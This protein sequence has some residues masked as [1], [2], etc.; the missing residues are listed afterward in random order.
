LSLFRS[1]IVAPIVLAALAVALA[2]SAEAANTTANLV[3]G[4]VDFAHNGANLADGRGLY[5]P[6]AVALDHSVTPNR[7]YVADYG[8][9]RVLGWSSSAN[10][11]N[12]KAANLVIGQPD[13]SSVVCDNGGVSSQTL[14]K[15]SGVAVD[16]GGN[17]YVADSGNNRVLEYNSPYSHAAVAGVGDNIANRVFGQS[18]FTS[19]A[20]TSPVSAST[21]CAPA[22]VAVDSGNNLY[23]ADS[24]NNRVLEYNTPLAGGN[25]VADLVFGQKSMT[26]A[27]CNF[28]SNSVGAS[29]LCLP[30]G[31]AADGAGNLYVGD[32][33]NNRVLKY[34]APVASRNTVADLVFGQSGF[35]ANA[36]SG[37]ASNTLCG[38]QGVAVDAAGNL[39]VADTGNRRALEYDT[40]L[41]ITSTPGSGDTIADRVFGQGN[42]FASTL[43]NLFG[44]A[45]AANSLCAPQGLATDNSENLYIADTGNS[46]LLEYITPLTTTGV[47]GSGDTVA[48]AVLGKLNFVH[49]GPNIARAQGLNFPLGMTI[50]TTVVPNHIYVADSGNNRVLGWQSVA[51][52]TN[53]RPA[54]LVIGQSDFVS[55][56]PAQNF[57]ASSLN[58]PE[59]VAVD[60]AGNLYVADTYSARVLEFNTPYLKTGVH[61][62]GDTTADMVFGQPNFTSGAANPLG[63]PT[64]NSMSQPVGVAVDHAGNLYVGEA[65][66]N[67]VLEFNNPVGTGN[68]TP[69]M[70][71]GQPNFTT[72]NNYIC[73]TQPGPHGTPSATTL[74]V[75]ENVAVDSAGNL[76]VNDHWYSRVLEYNNPVSTRSTTPDMVFGQPN[77]TTE[78]AGAGAS[79]LCFPKNAAADAAGNLYI[80]DQCNSRVLEYNTPVATGNTVADL[81]FGQLGNFN[82]TRCNIS[83]NAPPNANSLCKPAGM[84]VDSSGNLYVAD[85][86]NNRLLK[87]NHN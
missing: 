68:T 4:Q 38:P 82:A 40:P 8:N 13:F 81:V 46:R 84:G 58:Y 30:E 76:Y 27:G 2:V 75:P 25:I 72:A 24:K 50:D 54:D 47:S 29:S 57:T 64:A 56:A 10:F 70:V 44:T 18:N 14:C 62:S 39:Y 21:L 79:G 60:R 17:L 63:S 9:N 45:P 61:G 35:S 80:S 16:S 33:Q 74:C 5:S 59:G 3:L 71:F 23:I 32:T 49:G 65:G 55:S 83:V 66:N 86:A 26:S 12:G 1:L 48:D 7:I 34:T 22:S 43:C 28:G 15:P 78:N 67:R 36:C 41:T 42:N 73:N 77:F 11:A 85:T 6:A 53:G 19:S 31:V 37:A 52:L 51:A 87:Y 69:D 20:C